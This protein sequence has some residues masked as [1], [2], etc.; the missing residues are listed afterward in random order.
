MTTPVRRLLI[1]EDDAE[2]LGTWRRDVDEFNKKPDR[3]FIFKIYEAESA[4][5][6]TQILEEVNIDCAIVDLR[7]PPEKNKALDAVHGNKLRTI[8]EKEHPILAAIHTA[9]PAELDEAGQTSHMRSFTKEAGKTTEA[10]E[11]FEQ[12]ADLMKALSETNRR[13]KREAAKVLHGSVWPRW[14]AEKGVGAVPEQ[15][16]AIVTRQVV[17][18]LAEQFS[19]LG[20]D[21]PA[22][23]M[24]EFYYV[25]PM[26]DRLHTG[27]L[28]KINEIV[29]VIVTPQCDIA[30][31]YPA[32]F[33]L[34]KCLSEHVE[35][36]TIVDAVAQN[37]GQ[38]G[39]ATRDKITKIVTQGRGQRFHFLPPCGDKGGPWFVDFKELVTIERAHSDE[40]LRNRFASIAAY[41]VPNLV[42]RFASF[43]GRIGQPDLDVD[44]LVAHLAEE[45]RRASAH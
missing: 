42:H 43:I 1:A 26:R 20:G 44:A 2:Q 7:L 29:H 40:L 31:D 8:I 21:I 25:P 13:V 3:K 45:Y 6:A 17:S 16:D 18:H 9:H 14:E 28:V 23:H 30:N 37:G 41:F 38:I 12:K 39:K 24:H 4:G 19:L 10:L 15:F 34:A 35:W 5:E 27:D 11:W 22:Y 36:Q 32:N 33:L